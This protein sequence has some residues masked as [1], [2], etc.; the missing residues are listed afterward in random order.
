[1]VTSAAA[2]AHSTAR[3]TYAFRFTI[4]DHGDVASA[5]LVEE[6][7]VAQLVGITS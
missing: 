7:F 6:F 4:D 2:R 1:M 5:D 3:G